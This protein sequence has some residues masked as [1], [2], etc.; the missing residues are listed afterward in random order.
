MLVV[1]SDH[2]ALADILN[3]DWKTFSLSN[4]VTRLP[5]HII[6]PRARPLPSKLRS[7]NQPAHK[8]TVGNVLLLIGFCPS[9]R[10]V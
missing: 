3:S 5:K 10:T 7:N 9:I 4:I 8:K 2:T 6:H 1:E